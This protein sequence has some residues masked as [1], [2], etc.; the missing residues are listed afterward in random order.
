MRV[1]I[2]RSLDLGVILIA[3]LVIFLFDLPLGWLLG[4]IPAWIVFR[5]WWLYHKAKSDGLF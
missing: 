2:G 4:F 5:L 3:A 1:L